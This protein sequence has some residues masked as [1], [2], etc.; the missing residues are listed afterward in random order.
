MATAKAKKTVR[1]DLSGVDFE[2]AHGTVVAVNLEDFSEQT[3]ANLVCH[4]LSQKLGDSYSGAESSEQ[5]QTFLEKVLERLKAGEWT[6]AREGGGGRGVSQLVEALHRATGQPVEACNDLVQSMDDDQKKGLKEHSDI[7]A[8]L[9]EI[10][11]EK[12]AEAAAKAR[13]EQ[14][15]GGEEPSLAELLGG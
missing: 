3:I 5:A 11:A 13:A 1:E 9:A 8:A 10:R 14:A 7:K 12:A 6:A 4:G 15:A 2:F